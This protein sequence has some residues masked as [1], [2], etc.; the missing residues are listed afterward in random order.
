MGLSTLNGLA[1]AKAAAIYSSFIDTPPPKVEAK[2][3]W[4]WNSV[5][6]R[7]W[8]SGLPPVMADK[9]FLLIHNILPLRGRPASIG[10]VAEGSCPHCGALETTRHF[11]QLCP[12]KADLWDGLDVRLVTMVPG[13]PSD[14]ELLMLA[15]LALVA[16]VERVVVALVATLVLEVWETRSCLRPPSRGDLEVFLG[17][18][19]LL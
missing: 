18:I 1:G 9:M 4:D 6:A 14:L 5:W 17:C 3:P 16:S 19:S 7:L 2:W 13:L 12:R 15:F 8:S 10:V 11:F